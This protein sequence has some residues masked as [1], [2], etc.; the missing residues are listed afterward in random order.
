VNDKELKIEDVRKGRTDEVGFIVKRRIWDVVNVRECWERT[1]KGPVRVKWVDTDKGTGGKVDVRCRLVARDFKVKGE[2]DREDLFVATP[3]LE[4]RRVL[5]SRA[6]TVGRG[7]RKLMF[8]DAKKAHL[9]DECREVVFIE[10][11]P[12]AGEGPGKCGKLN[13]FFIWFRQ[14]AQAWK[15][16]YSERL[17]GVG[18]ERGVH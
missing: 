17:E 1:G 9:N 11:P 12:E 7:V 6:A 13:Y 2:K 16:L 8:V 3:L 10:L 14:A 15:Y 18:F 5:F 4:G